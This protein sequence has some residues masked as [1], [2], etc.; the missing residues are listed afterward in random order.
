V[1]T[2]LFLSSGLIERAGGSGRLRRV[3]G[4]VSETP[5]LAV[6]FLLPALSLAGVPPLSGFVSK[7]A[8]IDAGLAA[9]QHAIVAV[10]LV[11]SLLTV[12]SMIRI[13]SGVFWNPAEDPQD[14]AELAALPPT[15]R[16]GGPR[17]MVLPT[18]LLVAATLAVAAAAGPL[19]AFSERTAEELLDPVAYVQEVLGG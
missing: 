3:G 16:W 6:L 10:A 13:W 19:Y 2:T 12:L 8:L 17:L 5:F 18:A 15:S 11:V 7:F 9:D 1:K 4:M 14:A